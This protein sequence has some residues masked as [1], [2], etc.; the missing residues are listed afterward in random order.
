MEKSKEQQIAELEGLVRTQIDVLCALNR[1]LGSNIY[2]LL[3][4]KGI[5]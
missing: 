5:M 3:K 2:K 1:E 4:L